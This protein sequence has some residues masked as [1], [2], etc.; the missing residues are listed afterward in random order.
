VHLPQHDTRARPATCSTVDAP[1]PH[2]P[3]PDSRTQ[4]ADLRMLIEAEE[5][6]RS[7]G[8]TIPQVVA[9]IPAATTMRESPVGVIV[10]EKFSSIQAP[11]APEAPP[12]QLLLYVES[13]PPNSGHQD[14]VWASNRGGR[15]DLP[16]GARNL[17]RS[18]RNS[19]MHRWRGS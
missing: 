2:T 13:R 5:K 17:N 18:S 9:S 14:V 7:E 19:P 10:V 8:N 11:L 3:K 15:P 6:V 16:R 4:K 1:L 12:A